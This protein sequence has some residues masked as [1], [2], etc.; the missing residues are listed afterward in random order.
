MQVSLAVIAFE[1][2]FG[3][4]QI[5]NAIKL[6]RKPQYQHTLVLAYQ[7]LS[8]SLL[9]S[10]RLSLSALRIQCSIYFKESNF[11]FSYIYCNQLTCSLQCLRCLAQW[12]TPL[13]LPSQKLEPSCCLPTGHYYFPCRQ[14]LLLPGRS[15][16]LRKGKHLRLYNHLNNKK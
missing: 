8:I 5:V 2:L 6:I 10:E 3:N 12:L 4:K 7:Y 1:Y 13:G 15:P 11:S 14:K 9:L 16:L